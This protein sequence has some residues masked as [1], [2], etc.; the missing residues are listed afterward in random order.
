[1]TKLALEP[2]TE[3]AA[4]QNIKNALDNY[5]L[6]MDLRDPE[7]FL[8]AWH[9]DAVFDQDNPKGIFNG[10]DEILGWVEDVWLLYRLTVHV[11]TN[12]TIEFETETAAT[13]VGH[14]IGTLLPADGTYQIGAATYYDKYECRDGVWRM[15]FRKSA[16]NHIVT[17]PGVEYALAPAPRS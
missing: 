7:R 13:G 9:T 11:T 14:V 1:M 3:L 2:I 5:A 10:H 15:A 12:H 16:V 8:S 17:I 6:G 4:R